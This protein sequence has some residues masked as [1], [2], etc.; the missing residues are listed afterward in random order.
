[1]W[2]CLLLKNMV[3]F[4][5]TAQNGING[6]NGKILVKITF[7]SANLLYFIIAAL[8]LQ[9]QVASIFQFIRRRI[10]K[11]KRCFASVAEIHPWEFSAIFSGSLFCSYILGLLYLGSC[12]WCLLQES[13]Y[14]VHPSYSFFSVVHNASATIISGNFH[15]GG[16][17]FVTFLP[18]KVPL[19]RLFIREMRPSGCSGR[20]WLLDSEEKGRHLLALLLHPNNPE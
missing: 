8:T 4:G 18:S 17:M 20:S 1:M 13:A 6:D 12:D 5:F 10:E 19:G 11:W 9:S 16:V 15:S 2:I 14:D 7:A 3:E